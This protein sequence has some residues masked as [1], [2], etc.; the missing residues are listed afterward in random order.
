LAWQENASLASQDNDKDAYYTQMCNGV[1]R[2]LYGIMGLLIS[3]SPILWSLL[4]RGDYNDAYK[5]LPILYVA[6]LF[7]CMA[8]TLGGIYIAYK[9][10]KS[11][12]ITTTIAAV[13]NL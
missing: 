4:I 3:C 6:I 8:S 11:V 12:G 1:F 13:I 7:S 10:T 9:K 2:I 5:Q